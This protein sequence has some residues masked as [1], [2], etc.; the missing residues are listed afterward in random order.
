MLNNIISLNVLDAAII[1]I[2][3]V[4]VIIPISLFVA[5]LIDRV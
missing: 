2:V 5:L 4:A 1:S 3:S